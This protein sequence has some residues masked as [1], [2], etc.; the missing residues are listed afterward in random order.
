LH[1]T[2]PVPFFWFNVG[3]NKQR[4]DVAA[5]MFSFDNFEDYIK[6]F[7]ETYF[8][9]TKK[10]KSWS[11]GVALSE[12]GFQQ[13]SFVNSTD[14]YDGGTHLDYVL[15]QIISS[16]REFFN[17]KHKVDIKP[18]ELKN[19]MFIFL[20]ST[21]I[22]PSFSSQTKEKLITE[23]KEFGYT[24]EI[25]QKII[26]SILKSEIVQSVLDWIQQ[27]KNADE[28]KLARELNKNLSKIKVDK[29]IDA[30]GKERWKCSLALFE[31]DCLEENTEIRIIR[32]GDIINQKIKNLTTEDLVIT[33][34][35]TISN[36][37][38]LTKKIKKQAIIKVKGEDIVC[39]HEHKWFVYDKEK[40]EFYFEQTKNINPNKHK[41]VKNYLAFTSG[42][43]KITESNGYAVKLISGDIINTNPDHKFAVY[44]IDLNKFEMIESSKINP[45]QHCLV[46]T[47]KL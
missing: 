35:N 44:N 28:N 22:N 33:H 41:L 3:I 25:S 40:N 34:N 17:K 24:F 9:E 12:N 14:T 1:N 31:G 43:L 6:M 27:K 4:K 37:Y 10:D 39:S 38:A 19:H 46:N 20:N 18:S 32:D 30:K 21:I 13:V 16:L 36:I 29:L 15:N 8:Y 23:S 2:K 5:F 7:T 47:F 26:Q 42:L 45:T 11:I